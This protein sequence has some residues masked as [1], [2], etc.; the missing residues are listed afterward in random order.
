MRLSYDLTEPSEL[1][2]DAEKVGELVERARRE[3]DDGLLPSCQLAMAREGRVV[4]DVALGDAGPT[5]RYVIFS[6][7]KSVVGG[8]IWLLMSEGRLDVGQKVS[9]IVPEFATNGKD[10]ITV[11]QVLTHTSGFPLA[12][13]PAPLWADR[14]A[15]LERFAKWRLNWEPGSQYEYHATSAHWVLA[16]VIERIAGMDYRRFVHERILEPLGLRGPRLGVAEQDQSDITRLVGVGEPASAEELQ[17]VLGVVTVDVGE[18]T[19][20]ALLGLNEPAAK[21]AGVPGA[22]GVA[23]AADLA[24]WYQALLHNPGDLWDPDV[25]ADATGTIRCTFPDPMT[26]AASNRTLGLV[27]AG[28][29]GMSNLR[30]NM[31]RTVSPAAFGHA[32]AGGQIAWADPATGLSFA[33]V[34]NGLDAN[35]L[36]EARRSTALSSRAAVCVAGS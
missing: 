14:D 11:E 9:E 23:R 26:G 18:V 24:L 34:T 12:P 2:V 19:E 30:S 10:V 17:A 15:R 21:A 35:V 4:A 8:A 28:D 29:D 5:S 22:G 6:A 31:G 3:I 20:N 36:R 7:T 33:Y 1:G 13:M 16:E 25:L 27:V 32:G